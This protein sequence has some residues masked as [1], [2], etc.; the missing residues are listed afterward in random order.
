MSEEYEKLFT[1]FYSDFF[2]FKNG[3]QSNLKCPG[4][5]HNKRF[6]FNDN[7]LI[8]SCG[9]KTDP[10]CGK[11]YTIKLPK[12]IHYRTLRKVYEENMNGS[13]KYHKNDVM[14]Y[15]LSEYSKRM[16]LK[17]EFEEQRKIIKESSDNL[18]RLIDD[19]TQTNNL[20]EYIDDLKTLSEKRYKNSIEKQKIMRS[21]KEDELS[22]PEKVVLR[23]KYAVLIKEN[24]EFIELINKLNK[25]EN[26]FIMI[27]KSDCTV[28]KNDVSDEN[29]SEEKEDAKP[30]KEKVKK[31]NCSKAHP[32]PP[33]PPGKEVPD[34]KQC[35]YNEKKKNNSPKD[36]EEP[37][38]KEENKSEEPKAKKYKY[39]E[40]IEILTEYYKKVDPNKTKEDV[41][42]IINRRRN[43]GAPIG[44]RIPTKPWLELCETLNKKYNVH[45]LSLNK[46]S[47]KTDSSKLFNPEIV[48]QFY[49]KS[50][51]PEPGKGSGEKIPEDKISEFKELSKIKNWRKMLSNFYESEFT[52]DN[53]KW[54]SVEHYYQGA[55][56]KKDNLE[57]YEKFALDSGSDIGKDPN[58][59]KSAGGKSGKSK[60]KLLRP[61]NIKIDKDFF[62][63]NRSSQEM[64]AAQR[65]KYSQNEKLKEML[66]LTRDA[67]L[68]H[69]SR[70]SPPIEFTETMELREE[71]K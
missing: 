15:D 21:I 37:K 55:K 11:Q 45:P 34:G 35:C 8:Y 63:D 22:E 57:F 31:Q 12:Y 66:L 2:K 56:F 61:E 1:K 9:P 20:D 40:Q 64:K 70:G 18:K 30:K 46:N 52:L 43:K 29:K 58:L 36:P 47:L 67:K 41:I 65:E 53:K 38:A 16:D 7:E 62:K 51:D 14:Q 5:Q 44:T 6:I 3:K 50:R 27:E 71:F 10:K 13:F 17:T 33:C 59:A 19:Y 23:R 49:S 26:D 48:F 42:G 68:T 54:L 60:G 24:D 69:F 25:E 28:H 4:C 32:P 39:E